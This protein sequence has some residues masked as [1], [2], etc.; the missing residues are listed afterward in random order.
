MGSYSQRHPTSV[1]PLNV[2][3]KYHC[4]VILDAHRWSSQLFLW[5]NDTADG[6]LR[7]HQD[8][9]LNEVDQKSQRTL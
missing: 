4:Y 3:G 8:D 1:H 7:G 9:H 5:N 2:Q 6:Y